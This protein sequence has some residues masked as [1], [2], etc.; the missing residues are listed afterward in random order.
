MQYH[1]GIWREIAKK[2]NLDFLVIYIKDPRLTGEVDPGFSQKV[3]WDRDLRIGYRSL[4]LWGGIDEGSR[5][6][7]DALEEH[8]RAVVPDVVIIHGY[9]QSFARR[10]IRLRRRMNFKL[11]LRGEFTP[12][13]LAWYHYRSMIRWLY[14]RWFFRSVDEFCFIGKISRRF[15]LSMG[16]KRSRMHF[17]PYSIDS[18]LL[19]DN[20]ESSDPAARLTRR[21]YVGE[22]PCIIYVGKLIERKNPL[23][24]AE[25]VEK[26]KSTIDVKLILVGSGGLESAIRSRLQAAMGEDL[27]MPGFVNQGDLRRFYSLADVFVLP[28][29]YE[30]WGLVVN[31][32]ME[33][34]LPCIVSRSAGCAPDLIREGVNG[35]LFDP[36]D[37]SG[38]ADAL[39]NILLNDELRSSMGYMSRQIVQ[40][41]NQKISSAGIIKAI[42]AASSGSP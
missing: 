15:L 26:I 22:K 1:A 21:E 16:T 31:E 11:V 5:S 29:L 10:V 20:V 42:Q 28:S 30:T 12:A 3:V 39:R 17:S 40:K 37:V 41:Y 4:V 34:G 8:L 33:M 32:A 24:L 23:I 19:A 38:L 9:S 2:D 36:R 35:M 6:L 13:R 27:V 14:L 25:A 18:E 7:N